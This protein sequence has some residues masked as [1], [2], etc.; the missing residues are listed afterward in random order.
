M[1]EKIIIEMTPNLKEISWAEKRFLE[2]VKLYKD[3][4]FISLWLQ[5]KNYETKKS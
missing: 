1:N 2:A 4:D 5:G 3:H